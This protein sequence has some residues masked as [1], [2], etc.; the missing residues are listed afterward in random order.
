VIVRKC[1]KCGSPRIHRSR[2]RSLLERIRKSFTEKRPHRCHACGWRG[3][4]HESRHT[5]AA[6][7]A[8]A[9]FGK[10]GTAP[11]FNAIDRSL[12]QQ[13]RDQ[14]VRDA[15]ARQKRSAVNE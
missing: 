14:A 8:T 4:G 15:G 3:W 5:T 13:R 12:E 6:E 10:A 7:T 2:S 11:D 1:P 9:G